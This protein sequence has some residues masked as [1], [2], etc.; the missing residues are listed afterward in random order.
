MS[1]AQTEQE[2]VFLNDRLSQDILWMIFDFYAETDGP[3]DPLERL[4]FVCKYWSLAARQHRRLWTKFPIRLESSND[5]KFWFS[6]TPSRIKICGEEGPAEVE[7]GRRW[8]TDFKDVDETYHANVQN[9]S[10]VLSI[11]AASL[12]TL[13]L[14][15]LKE[16]V[17]LP[18]SFPILENVS[19]M[20]EVHPQLIG[21]FLAPQIRSLTIFP[22]TEESMIAVKNCRGIDYQRLET[23]VFGC[24]IYSKS[25]APLFIQSTKEIF[26]SVKGVRQLRALN[27][28]AVRTFLL[29]IQDKINPSIERRGCQIH[30][31]Y[32]TY[33][34]R[35]ID[36]IFYISADTTEEDIHRVRLRAKLPVDDTWDGLISSF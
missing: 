23:L 26:R 11:T 8:L 28:R 29:C 30:L 3:Q 34:H 33:L 27:P 16:N 4:L 1:T 9:I 12:T 21:Q 35:A 10:E 15:N 31:L 17:T 5:L 2:L 14:I 25:E 18:P 22:R 19:F 20:G 6:R 36:E 24:W 32:Y 7:F 13:S